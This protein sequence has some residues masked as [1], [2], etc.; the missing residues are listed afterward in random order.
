MKHINP[1]IGTILPNMLTK[2]FRRIVEAITELEQRVDALEGGKSVAP[3]K[4]KAVASH[5]THEMIANCDS[6]GNLKAWAKDLGI[7]GVGNCKIETLK[8]KLTDKLE[9]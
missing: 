4:N 8:E 2:R 9:A 3:V 6:L 5:L 7:K 1:I